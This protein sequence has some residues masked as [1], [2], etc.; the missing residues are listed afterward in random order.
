MIL[1][2]IGWNFKSQIVIF[3]GQVNSEDVI[4]G[5]NIIE[6]A[7]RCWEVGN[8]IF[9]HDNLLVHNSK[10]IKAIL[11]EL[12]IDVLDRPPDGQYLNVIKVIWAILNARIQKRKSTSIDELTPI[13]NR[14]MGIHQLGNNKRLLIQIQ[15][16]YR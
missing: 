1:G 12:G 2:A 3:D 9:Q 8:W 14:G 16:I 5:S 10:G 13:N 15:T 11:K 7:D 4:F 6:D